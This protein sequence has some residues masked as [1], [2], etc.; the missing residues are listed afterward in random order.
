[1]FVHEV[2]F[3]QRQ[4]VHC[5][6]SLLP[7]RWLRKE[8]RLVCG[9]IVAC[10]DMWPGQ[11][12]PRELDAPGRK[13][14]GGCRGTRSGF[15]FSGQSKENSP[16]IRRGGRPTLPESIRR[17]DVAGVCRHFFGDPYFFFGPRQAAGERG[18]GTNVSVATG[19][20]PGPGG[21]RAVVPLRVADPVAVFDPQCWRAV[22]QFQSGLRL[23]SGQVPTSRSS[24]HIGQGVVCRKNMFVQMHC[25]YHI[26]GDLPT[27]ITARFPQKQ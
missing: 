24:R 2:C 19:A 16:T 18:N 21:C 26:V 8:Y 27:R 23:F 9:W 22:Q 13:E 20:C 15:M 14:T 6:G 12:F 1:M 7:T 4:L 5:D 10:L 25:Q 3:F 17:A 11:D